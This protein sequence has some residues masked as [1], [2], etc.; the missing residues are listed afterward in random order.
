MMAIELSEILAE[1]QRVLRDIFRRTGL[2]FR[3]LGGI[4]RNDTEVMELVLPIAREWIPSASERIRGALYMQFLTPVSVPYLEDI[5]D[6]AETEKSPSSREILTQVLRLIASPTT[7]SRIWEVFRTL[8]PTDS[9][10]LLLAKLAGARSVSAEVVDRILRFLNSIA[11]R[12]DR[13]DLVRT[14]ASGPLEEYSRVR[15]PRIQQWFHKYLNSADAEL[16]AMAKRSCRI[17]KVLPAIG[18]LVRGTPERARMVFSTEID[19]HCLADLLLDVNRDL[20]AEFL[21]G[22]E[23]DRV[24]ENLVESKWLVCEVARSNKGPLELWLRLEDAGTIKVCVLG[25]VSGRP[26]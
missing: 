9:D 20:S 5:L 25:P 18:R 2:E 11:E 4:D 22:V 14:F 16:R 10:P 8:D 19:L 17:K 12:I 7:A 3:R 26:S 15:H 24:V 1:E 13:G 23:S 21:I 6:W